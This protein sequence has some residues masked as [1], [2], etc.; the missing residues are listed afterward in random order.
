MALSGSP[1][2]IA[3]SNSHHGSTFRFPRG[4]PVDP[5]LLSAQALTTLGVTALVPSRGLSN[6]LN[7]NVTAWYAG[8]EPRRSGITLNILQTLY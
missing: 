1:T 7:Q 6:N 8:D 3:N 4:T 2:T 5:D